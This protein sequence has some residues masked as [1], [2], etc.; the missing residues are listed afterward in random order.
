MQQIDILFFAFLKKKL[1]Q[2]DFSLRAAISLVL[3]QFLDTV[4][5][6]FAGLYGIVASVM[7]IILISLLVKLIVI[8]CFTPI[9]RWAK[10]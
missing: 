4:L 3:S 1:P 7:D 2:T 9:V 5:F 10:A 8:S 6:S